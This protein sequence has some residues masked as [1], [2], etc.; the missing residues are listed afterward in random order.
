MASL[1]DTIAAKLNTTTLQFTRLVSSFGTTGFGSGTKSGLDSFNKQIE[2][3]GNGL[4]DVSEKSGFG[5][6]IGHSLAQGVAKG[7][8]DIVS[9]PGIQIAMALVTKIAKG[10]GSF[11]YQ[12]SR[13]FMGLNEPMK[14]QAAVQQS[15][16]GFLQQNVGLVNQWARGQLSLNTLVGVYLQTMKNASIAQGQMTN[17]VGRATPLVGGS[18]HA[19][20]VAGSN[21]VPNFGLP[22][23]RVGDKALSG[24]DWLS[25]QEAIKKALVREKSPTATV[26]F[27]SIIASPQNPLGA[28]VY[29]KAYQKSPDDAFRQHLFLGQT[30]LK[31]M[32]SSI[33]SNR[34]VPNFGIADSLALGALQGTFNNINGVLSPLSYHY[35]KQLELVRKMNEQ[36][37]ALTSQIRAGGIVKYNGNVYDNKTAS[38]GISV[39][40]NLRDFMLDFRQQ[41]RGFTGSP[42]AQGNQNT[43]YDTYRQNVQKTQAKLST[44]ATFGMVGAPLALETG[45]SFAKNFGKLDLSKGLE[46]FSA[47]VTEAGQLLSTFP[48]KLG[49]MLAS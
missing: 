40:Q 35:N 37:T 9:G 15:I 13:E 28:L 19:G 45:A 29:D 7:L 46:S 41:N 49:V 1:N 24:L 3:I 4:D 48:N 21:F 14:Q 30:D 17:M 38:G 6:K 18:V 11:A 31:N 5:D 2:A 26:G 8:G 34:F 23:I 16:T 12:S 33:S 47:G 39:A 10:L 25:E 36:Y 44:Y 20:H 43:A 22:N 32:G 42:L 27:S